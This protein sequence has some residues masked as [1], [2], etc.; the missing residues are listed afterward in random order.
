MTYTMDISYSTCLCPF[1]S[2]SVWYGIPRDCKSPCQFSE[3]L[4]EWLITE[5]MTGHKTVIIKLVP[6]QT[7]NAQ[8]T[9][10][11]RLAQ[12]DR[13][14]KHLQNH[15]SIKGWGIQREH[16]VN[17]HNLGMMN[18]TEAAKSFQEPRELLERKWRL[19]ALISIVMRWLAGDKR[20][21]VLFTVPWTLCSKGS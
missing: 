7:S 16:I 14:N 18:S 19:A 4:D 15:P 13:G 3:W 1:C 21:F 9:I 5:G 8:S 2:L 10:I 11:Y 17:I 6:M 20:F 12:W